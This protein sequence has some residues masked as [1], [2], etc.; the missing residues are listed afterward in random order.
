MNN[1]YRSIWNPSLGCY[2]AA[3][4]CAVSHAAGT[5]CKRVARTAPP[6]RSKSVMVLES[7]VLFDGAVV[8]TL[9][10]MVVVPLL[11]WELRKNAPPLADSPLHTETVD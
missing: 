8:A 6:M 1:T 7:R 5:S 9:L 11:Y 10:T 4:E 3:P 2:V